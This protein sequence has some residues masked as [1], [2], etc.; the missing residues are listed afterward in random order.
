MSVCLCVCL[1]LCLFV[2]VFVCLFVCLSVCLSLSP[3]FLSVYLWCVFRYSLTES[4]KTLAVKLETVN[5]RK[6]GHGS[7]QTINSTHAEQR[8]VLHGQQ[9]WDTSPAIELSQCYYFT[10]V[11][12]V[13]VSSDDDAL[14]R[15]PLTSRLGVCP[16]P[17]VPSVYTHGPAR[18]SEHRT[19]QAAN[20]T[21][22]Q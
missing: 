22:E 10:D 15:E 4:G 11:C 5:E 12:H 13:D 21:Q 7:P 6:L 19:I 2:S 20:R 1:S 18:P 8:H 17:S 3:L 9:W 14:E 16:H